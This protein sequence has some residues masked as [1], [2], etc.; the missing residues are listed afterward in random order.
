MANYS[1]GIGERQADQGEMLRR[2]SDNLNGQLRVALPGIIQSFDATAQTV[3]V[4]CAIR[5]RIAGPDKSIQ[6]IQIP[7]LLD[8]PI[9][10]PRAGGFVI[11]FPIKAGDECLVVFSDLCIDAWFS[12]GGIQ[13]PIEYRRHDFSDAFAILGTWS[14]PRKVSSYSTSNLEIKAEDVDASIKITPA[15]DIN[16][17]GRYVT[18]TEWGP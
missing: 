1:Q 14:Q 11:T 17:R 15:G 2:M 16:I 13:N 4:N 6:N 10:L 8:V 18:T 12:N 3:T 9:V 7:T 5:E